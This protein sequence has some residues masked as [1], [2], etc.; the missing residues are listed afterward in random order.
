[1]L[2]QRFTECLHADV[3][4]DR[5]TLP[6][7]SARGIAHVFKTSRRPSIHRGSLP[8]L[9]STIPVSSATSLLSIPRSE[10]SPGMRWWWPTSRTRC[11]RCAPCIPRISWITRIISIRW[12]TVHGWLAIRLWTRRWAPWVLT[13]RSRWWTLKW[14]GRTH[15]GGRSLTICL[16]E[17]PC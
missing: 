16:R 2:V 1:M 9:L 10:S 5:E 3:L 7:R 6:A 8:K 13:E 17:V 12:W 4:D 11:A 15:G 14:C